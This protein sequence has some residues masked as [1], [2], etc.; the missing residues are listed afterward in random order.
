MDK[1]TIETYNKVAGEY[2]REVADFWKLFPRGVIDA[3]AKKVKRGGRVLDVGSGSGRDALILKGAGLSVTCLDASEAMIGL[4]KKKGFPSVLADFS[5]IPFPDGS[6][7]GAWA[8]TSLLHVAK[9]KV[10]E[11]LAEIRRVLKDGRI[12]GLGMIEGNSEEY[13]ESAG[14]G[15][16]R[17]FAYYTKPELEE[18]LKEAGFAV[19]HFDT[20][21]P[22]SRDYLH[23]LARK[24]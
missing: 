9:D 12:L 8:Y 10:R 5:G 15:L 17:Y 11:P 23:F 3:F 1:K 14:P 13:R 20:F 18:L 2:D 19:F 22:G 4:T 24:A 21:K 16:P 7:D 6:F